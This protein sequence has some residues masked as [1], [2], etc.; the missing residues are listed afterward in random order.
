MILKILCVHIKIFHTAWA[1]SVIMELDSN[2]VV[3][4]NPWLQR[5]AWFL[6]TPILDSA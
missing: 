4:I 6:D 2:E 1:I 5:N 3:Y